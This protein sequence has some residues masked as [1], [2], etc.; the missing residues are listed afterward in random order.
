M[1]YLGSSSGVRISSLQ[2]NRG[3]GRQ[4]T[5]EGFFQQPSQLSDRHEATPTKPDTSGRELAPEVIRNADSFYT[6]SFIMMFWQLEKLKGVLGY[7]MNSLIIR[8]Q[9]IKGFKAF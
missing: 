9:L 6:S 5:L 2:N 8:K 3:K 1:R 7:S 4:D